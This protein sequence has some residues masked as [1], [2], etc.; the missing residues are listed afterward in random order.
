[1]I[2]AFN[3]GTEYVHTYVPSILF[4]LIKVNNV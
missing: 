3:E 1:M 2:Y 4:Y